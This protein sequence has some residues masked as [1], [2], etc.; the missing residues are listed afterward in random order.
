M[1]FVQYANP[2]SFQP[3]TGRAVVS[4]L[5]CAVV[6]LLFAQEPLH[7]KP[8]GWVS[9]QVPEP[10]DMVFTSTGSLLVV[11]DNGHVAEIATD[12]SVIRMAEGI[13]YDLEALCVQRGEWLAVDER[14]RQLI[15]L[16]SA[17]L[18]VIRRLT[19]PYAGGRNKGYEALVW[20]PVKERY[21]LIT[22]REPVYVF[23]LDAEW[24]VTSEQ[25]FDRQVRD[26]A[27]A[28]W[29][30]G[31]VWLLSDMDRLVLRCDPV[32]LR[33]TH[34]YVVP[35]I[36]PEGLAFDKNGILLVLSD[37]RQRIY[38]FQLPSALSQ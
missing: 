37:D 9:V 25:V 14:A 17:D 16:D 23:E 11:S 29:H 35:V 1:D 28:T 32:D 34:R 24:R 38:S 30:D 31:A 19:V 10:S 18:R 3:M 15:W 26:I 12:G 13:G 36:N 8:T 27:S 2:R 4:V 6:P 33:I 20:N 7:L 22:E 5:A 21:L